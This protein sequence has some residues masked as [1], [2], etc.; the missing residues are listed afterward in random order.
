MSHIARPLLGWLLRVNSSGA[1]TGL[2]RIHKDSLVDE[3]VAVAHA[4]HPLAEHHGV[5]R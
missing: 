2:S 5:E 3:E 4:R 1:E